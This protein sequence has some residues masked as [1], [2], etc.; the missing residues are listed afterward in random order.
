M[1][2]MWAPT[3]RGM[4]RSSGA[5]L[6]DRATA[7]LTAASPPLLEEVTPREPAPVAH[8]Q[9]PSAALSDQ[10]RRTRRAMESIDPD[11]GLSLPGA[12]RSASLSPP[13]R[14]V[15]GAAVVV[16][17]AISAMVWRVT[18]ATAISEPIATGFTASS[19]AP[20]PT[21]GPPPR[22]PAASA[23]QVPV[24]G[25]STGQA[26]PHLVIHVIGRVAKPGVVNVPDG[27]RIHDVVQ[28]AGGAVRG[29]DLAAVNLARRALDGEQLVIPAVGEVQPPPQPAPNSAAAQAPTQTSGAASAPMDLNTADQF[30]LE[31]LPGVGPVL[32]AR[33]IAWRD[34]HGR[35]TSVEELAEVTGVG[36]KR[37]AELAPRVRV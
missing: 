16:V 17:I 3:V 29:A 35:F 30:A 5:H 18:S 11:R 15:I 28:A 21:D 24:G 37:Y 1:P 27:S 20:A 25:E 31:T 4:S 19:S 32:A 13:W 33:I 10:A 26:R 36:E 14:A 34:Q 22:S 6:S 2:R 7:L 12:L 9:P 23:A 8:P